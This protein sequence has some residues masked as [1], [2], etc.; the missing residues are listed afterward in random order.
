M[1]FRSV[2]GLLEYARPKP[3]AMEEVD[4]GWLILDTVDLLQ[5][6]GQLKKCSIDTSVSPALPLVRLD[7]HQLQQVI[8]NL[9]LNAADAMEGGGKMTISAVYDNQLTSVMICVSDTGSGIA[10]DN[11]ARIFDPFFT[12]KEPGRGT[13]L[14]LS[15]AARI[16]ESFGGRITVRS[17][18][19]KGS[20]FT[21]QLPVAE[22]HSEGGGG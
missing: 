16:L 18:Y 5:H 8:I 10:Q 14:G 17:V 2:R 20:T 12:T 11:L 4:V 15:I 7:P 22:R 3:P 19:G 6:Q 1:L 13:G 9:M 21:L